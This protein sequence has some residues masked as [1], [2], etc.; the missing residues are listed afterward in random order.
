MDL[1]RAG[2][3]ATVGEAMSTAGARTSEHAVTS[4]VLH[5]GKQYRASEKAVVEAALERHPG[6]VSVVAYAIVRPLASSDA[7]GRHACFDDRHVV[8]G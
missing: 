8:G 7:P 2:A 3:E 6:V 4:V 5:V 1:P